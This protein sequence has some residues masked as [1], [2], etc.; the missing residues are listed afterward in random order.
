MANILFTWELGKDLGHIASTLPLALKLRESGHLVFIAL[1]DLSRAE[2]AIGMHGFPLF[3]APL[4]L[5]PAT[6]LPDP[7]L[8]YTEILLRYGYFDKAELL[9]LLRGWLALFDLVS[10]QVVIA[11]YAPTALLAARV[12][13]IP[14]IVCGLGFFSPPRTEPLPNMRPWMNVPQKRLEQSDRHALD[15]ANHALETLG[16]DPMTALRELFDVDADLLLSYPELDAYPN[17]NG[18]EYFGAVFGHGGWDEPVWPDG[19]DK[20]IFVYLKD[21]LPETEN[22][23][24]ALNKLDCR[25]LAYGPSLSPAFRKKYASQRI[26][27]HP[28]LMDIRSAG[29]EC[30]IGICHASH[31]TVV[32]ILL[33]GK[34]LLLLPMHLEQFLVGRNVAR[35]GAGIVVHPDVQ[36]SNS[37]AAL[38]KL[39]TDATYKSGAREFAEKYRGYSQDK[40][41]DAVIKRIE[42]VI[43][44]L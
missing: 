27:F 16:A 44:S 35:L 26:R 25:V 13:G 23:F 12:Q 34:P 32:A 29:E 7:P 20:K 41:V 17:R 21:E 37:L 9:S 36:G 43:A 4:C 8:N 42:T 30:D 24:A 31:G 39:M 1:R 2:S 28:G 40:T 38:Q 11:D 33:A 6:S 10:P 14:R 5:S 3:Q 22:T 18:G 19:E 15:S